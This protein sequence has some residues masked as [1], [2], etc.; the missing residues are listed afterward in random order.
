MLRSPGDLGSEENAS[1]LLRLGLDI[2]LDVIP[3]RLARLSTP[4]NSILHGTYISSFLS[5]KYGKASR[6]PSDDIEFRTILRR[7]RMD[8]LYTLGR[9]I[10]VD[11]GM[12]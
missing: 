1:A 10:H 11:T 4:V 5:S 6:Q 9:P 7:P 8:H 12:Y 3:G 2:Y